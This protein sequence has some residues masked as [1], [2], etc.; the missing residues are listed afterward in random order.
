MAHDARTAAS[1]AARL[2]AALLAVQPLALPVEVVA[3]AAAASAPY[4]VL[5]NTMSDLG[6][7]TCTDVAYAQGPVEVC[8]PLNGLVSWSWIVLGLALSVAAVLAWPRLRAGRRGKAGLA[9]LALSGP[10]IAAAGVFPVDVA[11]EAHN[12][13]SLPAFLLIPPALILIGSGMRS[14]GGGRSSG[15]WLI[16]LGA[17]AAIGTVAFLASAVVGSLMGLAQRIAYW[18]L[19]PACI[20]LALALWRPRPRAAEVKAAAAPGSPPGR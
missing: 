11:Y 12:L 6:A 8:S 5:E 17:I 15:A 18:P 14:P 20:I 19:Y 1:P 7:R 9:L 16:A 13:L 10:S 2:P 4:S 3:A